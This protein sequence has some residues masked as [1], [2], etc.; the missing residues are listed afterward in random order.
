M[1]LAWHGQYT[2][3]IWCIVLER[4]LVD[5]ATLFDSEL[6]LAMPLT[7]HEFS[8]ILITLFCDLSDL[9]VRLVILPAAIEG[10]STTLHSQGTLPVAL[11][12]NEVASV[13]VAFGVDKGTIAVWES[14]H[15]RTFI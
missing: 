5:V 14:I 8:D 6:S 10:D 7:I 9:A 2:L 13:R 12:L 11:A 1:Q 15:E 4:T 3:S